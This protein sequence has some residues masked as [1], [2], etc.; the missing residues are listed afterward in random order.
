[1]VFAGYLIPLLALSSQALASYTGN[2]NY[3]SPS[4]R[5]ARLGI[6]LEKVTARSLSKR[7]EAP[8]EPSQLN[9]THGVASG[10]PYA[11]SVVLWTRVAPSME[12][13]ESDVT[14]SGDVPLYDHETE[15]YVRASAHPVC[16][17]Y[18]VF[19]EEGKKKVVD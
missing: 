13:D 14:V 4:L 9:F 10:D 8:Y 17:K 2:L 7:D 19:D 12:S 16:V 5:H 11:D 15:G 18:R 6:D 3:R 1:M